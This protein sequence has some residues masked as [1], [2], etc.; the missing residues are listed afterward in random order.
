MPFSPRPRTSSSARP[1]GLSRTHTITLGGVSLIPDLSGALYAPDYGTLL[2]A[3]VH[4]EKGSSLARRGIHLPPYDTRSSLT[5]LAG[6]VAGI[7]PARL[8]FLGD[9]FHDA[10]A[11]E[12]IN[13]SDL[14]ELKRIA[15]AQE[16]LWITGNHDPA[17]PDDIGGS[18]AA[19]AVLGPITL[20]HEP[21]SLSD[22]E[23]EI[24]GHLHP[25]A[26]VHQRGRGIRCRCFIG[27]TRR[28]VMPAFGSYTGALSVSA[29]PF[30][31]IFESFDVWMLGGRA[32]HRLPGKAVR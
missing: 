11:R 30:Q 20:R 1:C 9:S 31:H 15:S 14:A 28:I 7:K 16:T 13:H 8:I 3:D 21:S 32:V 5:Q 29:E 17:P 22:G 23:L 27:D 2:V 18:I 24:A 12:R 10:E 4:L 25:G 26:T 6:V 19:M